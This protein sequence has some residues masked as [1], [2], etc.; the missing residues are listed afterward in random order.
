MII[1]KAEHLST[2]WTAVKPAVLSGREANWPASTGTTLI[3]LGRVALG[4]AICCI[5]TPN[6]APV[7]FGRVVAG[8]G[9]KG[10]LAM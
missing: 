4:N 9:T 1:N 6:C 5:P 8:T 10:S 2:Y 7:L 3:P